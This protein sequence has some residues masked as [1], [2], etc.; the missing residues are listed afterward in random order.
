MKSADINEILAGSHYVIS[1][2][3]CKN[4]D[5]TASILHVKG[6]VVIDGNIMV[7]GEI[8]KKVVVA[9]EEVTQ[10][11][12]VQGAK[13]IHCDGKLVALD[14]ALA[15][16]LQCKVY[17][18]GYSTLKCKECNGRHE[19]NLIACDIKKIEDAIK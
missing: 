12:I 3:S 16:C 1:N 6:D 19:A 9:W 5:G 17:Y 18:K 2:T 15:R 4:S 10:E 11:D 8:N 7:A 14:D 13:C